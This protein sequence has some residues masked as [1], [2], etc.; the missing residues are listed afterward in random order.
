M[1]KQVRTPISIAHICKTSLLLVL[2]MI[3]FFFLMKLFNMNSILELRYLNI[4]FFFFGVRHILLH[5][6]NTDGIKVPFHSAMMIGFLA[7]FLTAAFF[8][9]FVFSYLSIDTTFMSMVK[10]SQ[11]F[12]RYLS[13]ASASFVTFLEGVASGAIIAIP[14][15]WTMRKTESTA[16]ANE[17]ISQLAN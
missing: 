10:F 5:K 8:A 3:S 12:G 1:Q 9:A 17:T 13:P 6:Q 16:L 11:P 15:L 7:V 2:G 14:V 4:V